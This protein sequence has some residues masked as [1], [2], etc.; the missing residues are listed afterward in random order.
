MY[1][2]H[3][4]LEGDVWI[5]VEARTIPVGFRDVKIW[6]VLTQ[7]DTFHNTLIKL[8]DILK[9]DKETGYDNH[10]ESEGTSESNGEMDKHSS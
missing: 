5:V 3:N 8:I 6:V 2:I 1:S 7:P 10:D 9:R 4:L